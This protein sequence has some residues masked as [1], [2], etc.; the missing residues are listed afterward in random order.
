MVLTRSFDNNNTACLFKEKSNSGVK[1]YF[2]GKSHICRECPQ[3]T[4]L[5]PVL[6]KYIGSIMEDFI[7]DNFACP[8]C[9]KHELTV[10]GNHS[11]S[12][13]IVCLNC[14]RKFEGSNR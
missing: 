13:D 4:A 2:C 14:K 7:G 9:N 3:E 6:K 1:C 8:C 12:L 10:L 11:P 5:A